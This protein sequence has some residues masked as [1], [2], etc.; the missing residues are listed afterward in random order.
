MAQRQDLN[1]GGQG[2]DDLESV[3]ADYYVVKSVDLD[4][5]KMKIDMALE[6]TASLLTEK[7]MKKMGGHD[8]ERLQV[9]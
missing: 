9:S 7:R 2:E 4:K 8:K 3:A 6:G 1:Q 5:L